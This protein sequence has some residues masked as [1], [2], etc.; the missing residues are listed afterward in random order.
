MQVDKGTTVAVSG[1]DK[2]V[3]GD[4]AA[5]VRKQREPEPYKGKGVRYLGEVIKLKEG[6]SAAGKKSE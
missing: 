3:I 5:R 1:Y 4:F 6:K 2:V